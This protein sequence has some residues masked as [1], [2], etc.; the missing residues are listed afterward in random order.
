MNW[1]NIMQKKRKWFSIYKKEIFNKSND[2]LDL[3]LLEIYNFKDKT[4]LYCITLYDTVNN[5]EFSKI[6]KKIYKLKKN[7]DYKV[8]VNYRKKSFKSINYIRPQFDHTGNASLANI[9]LLNDNCLKKIEIS[10]SQINN[11]DAMIEY[12]CYFNSRIRTIKDI[13]NIIRKEYNKLSKPQYSLFYFNIDFLKDDFAQR[14]DL[15]FKYLRQ[16]IQYKIERLLFSHY[17]KK[18]LLPI[19][20][21]YIFDKKTKKA[22]SMIKKPFLIQSFIVDKDQ[23][24]L[25]N[26]IEENEGAEINEM[27]FK[28]SFNFVDLVGIASR[29]RMP[30]Y[31]T[32]FYNIEKTELETRISKYLNSKK[33]LINFWNYKWLINKLRKLN[34]KRIFNINYEKETKIKGY[35]NENASLISLSSV[36][37]IKD[38]YEDNIEFIKSLNALNYNVIAF[39]ISVLAL[40]IAIISIFI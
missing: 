21:S 28:K 2:C 35:S 9:D 20:F 40:I 5:E 22:I 11:E 38:V 3:N 17:I 36:E 26:S 37:G 23:Y 10:F 25:L 31:Y 15:E 30:F 16:I 19:K 6:I 33:I 1:F 8:D 4:E 12:K 34:E 7:K 27:I 24:L 29:L 18:Y 14:V 32:L 13:H 39:S